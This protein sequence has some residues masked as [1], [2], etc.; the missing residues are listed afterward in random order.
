MDLIQAA[1]SGDIIRVRELLDRGADPNSRHRS[2][3]T[4][5]FDASGYGYTEIAK[6]LLDR[7]ADPNIKNR[8]GSTALIWASEYGRTE[9]AKLLLDR[10]ANPNIRSLFGMTALIQASE[11]DRIEIVKLLLDRGADPNIIGRWGD[12]ALR[13]AESYGHDYIVRLIQGHIA[14]LQKAQQKLAFS[15]YL[16]DYDDLDQDVVSRILGV[17]PD[18][19]PDVINRM[20]R[21]RMQLI[22]QR[23][24]AEER[25][26]TI[27]ADYVNDLNLDQYG[28]GSKR[29]SSKRRRRKNYTRRRIFF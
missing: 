22:K 5:L 23:R 29:S 21:E 24:L 7:G 28:S 13:V 11:E 9:T 16:M 10:G 4:A 8:E 27:I 25:E 6:L 26:N 2:G 3:S 15:K 17:T 1:E 19:Y 20:H 12:T 14:P 18:Y